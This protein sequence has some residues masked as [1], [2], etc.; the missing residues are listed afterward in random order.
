MS[1]TP[2]R[3]HRA[4]IVTALPLERDALFPHLTNV[5]EDVHTVG[6]VYHVGRFQGINHSWE[7]AT[8]VAGMHNV[9]AAIEAERIITHYQPKLLL[10]SGVAGGLKDVELGDVVAATKVYYYEPGKDELEFR[11]RPEVSESSYALVQRAMAVA[12]DRRWLARAAFVEGTEPPSAFVKP[13]AAGSKVVA[14]QKAQSFE[15]L[16]RLFSDAAAVDMESYGFL[17]GTYAHPGVLSLVVRGISD[18]IENKTEADARGGQLRAAANSAAF[19]LQV[20]AEFTPLSLEQTPSTNAVAFDLAKVDALE[21]V[22]TALYPLGPVDSEIWSRAGGDLGRIVLTGGGRADWH[23]A[24][25]VLRNGGG[26]NSITIESLL[27]AM[28]EDF[29]NQ[30]ELQ[31]LSLNQARRLPT[32]SDLL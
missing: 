20:L 13:I 8:V 29:P 3:L 4:A 7:V 1:T 24:L 26:G 22:A 27:A 21:K 23:A 12:S 17:R 11:P 28:C 10:F 18:L 5:R 15:V 6:T 16:R 32:R 30:V 19:V 14:S 9:N 25:R 31:D 2:P